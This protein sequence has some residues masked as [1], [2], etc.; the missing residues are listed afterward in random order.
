MPGSQARRIR[1]IQLPSTRRWNTE[2]AR[3]VLSQLDAS[4]MGVAE[5]A[6]RAGIDAQRLYRW[7]AQLRVTPPAF[8]EI[9]R[10][11]AAQ[12]PIEIVLRSGRVVRVTDGFGEDALRRLVRALEDEPQC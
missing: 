3:A 10:A 9:A 11:P 1:P 2:D 12:W 7:R 4:R 6:A 8:V 5:F